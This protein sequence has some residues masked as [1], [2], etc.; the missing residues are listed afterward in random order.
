MNNT[1]MRLFTDRLDFIEFKQ[2][3]LFLKQPNHKALQFSDLSINQFLDIK[4][5]VKDFETSIESGA[6]YTINDFETK[7]FG[8]CP[9][10]KTY[11]S[12]AI[13]IARILMARENYDI[14][15]SSNN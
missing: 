14:L 8:V 9:S 2:Q 3:F 4:N 15:F 6:T 7:L 11:P 1:D 12:G 5:F 10:I 13:L